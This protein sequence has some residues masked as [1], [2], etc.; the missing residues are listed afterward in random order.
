MQPLISL[1]K[2]V[3]MSGLRPV[4]AEVGSQYGKNIPYSDGGISGKPASIQP[5]LR[6]FGEKQASGSSLQGFD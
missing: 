3:W 4:A 2:R 1:P 6:I 5:K